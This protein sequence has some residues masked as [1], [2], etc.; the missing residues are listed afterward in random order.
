MQRFGENIPKVNRTVRPLFFYC[1]A[2]AGLDR[3]FFCYRWKVSKATFF[4]YR[5]Q[6]EH[7]A[8]KTQQGRKFYNEAMILLKTAI[9]ERRFV[10][11]ID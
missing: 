9:R 1:V 10:S 11:I 8:M 5:R 7:Y 2:Q 3:P 4:R 6:G